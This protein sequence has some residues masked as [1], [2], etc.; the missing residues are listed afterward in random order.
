[1]RDLK[2]YKALTILQ[3]ICVVLFTACILILTSC[4]QPREFEQ[5]QETKEAIQVVNH[6]EKQ[7]IIETLHNDFLV[8]G[9][10]KITIDSNNTFVVI[11]NYDALAI[12][13]LK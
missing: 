3:M 12:E 9:V 13:R 5:A 2:I 8:S 1:M 10:Y 11:S 7:I 6:N 4:S